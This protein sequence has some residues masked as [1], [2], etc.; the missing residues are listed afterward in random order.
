MLRS[1]SEYEAAGSQLWKGKA[2]AL[3]KSSEKTIREA[4][5]MEP[6]APW[7]AERT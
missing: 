1:S 4:E 2:K 7:G 5:N 6:E 3:R